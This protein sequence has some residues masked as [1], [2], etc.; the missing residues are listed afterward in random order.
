MICPF[1]KLPLQS[2]IAQSNPYPEATGRT[3]GLSKD[4]PSDEATKSRVVSGTAQP[5]LC[6]H[7]GGGHTT[8]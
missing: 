5:P 8:E 1:L 6:G 7:E 4:A 3:E 2:S